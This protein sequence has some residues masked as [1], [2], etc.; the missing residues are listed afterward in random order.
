[1]R[2]QGGDPTPTA[3]EP[4]SAAALPARGPLGLG[5]RAGF[6]GVQFCATVTLAHLVSPAEFGRAAMAG[7]IGNF[8][9]V[10]ADLG[11]A[12]A[13]VQRPELAD[14][15]LDAAFGVSLAAAAALLVVL[16]A[17]A[18][19]LESVFAGAGVAPL[20]RLQGV[21]GACWIAGAVPRA[22]LARGL[23]TALLLRQ[24]LLA[25]VL[26]TAAGIAGALAGLGAAAVVLMTAVSCA[27][28]TV[29]AYRAARVR[30]RLRGLAAASP[31]LAVGLPLAALNVVA[32]WARSVDSLLIGR[33][34]GPVELGLYNRAY[35][36]MLLPLAQAGTLAASLLLPA[37]ARLQHDREAAR[38]TYLRAQGA[39]A[40]V[41]MPLLAV[42]WSA[43]DDL[44]AVLFGRA[45][46][47][48]GE[49]LRVLLLAGLLQVTTVLV[50]AACG[51][52]GQ[53]RAL[54]RQGL[55]NGPLTM[56]AVFWGA[57]YGTA[58]AVAW[59]YVGATLVTSGPVVRLAG[60]TLGFRVRDVLR[61]VAPASGCA[62]VAAAAVL[63]L[64]RLLTAWPA[65]PRLLVLLAAGALTYVALARAARIPGAEWL[66]VPGRS[67]PALASG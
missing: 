58:A 61:V 34:A 19:V 17:G 4:A 6:L 22:L 1:M 7:V 64:G 10:V 49:L 62:L 33:W 30:P 59:A 25:A 48:A 21:A 50:S 42:A 67:R 28:A 47:D 66:S 15:E 43:A 51:S 60:R 36:L 54:L 44:V 26:A 52:H 12:T 37:L 23:R 18:P 38:T 27:A 56:A 2:A 35:G 9:L 46:R 24:E 31:L 57:T 39:L 16:L 45:W 29:L 41:V 65:P 53:T 55:V 5:W 20:L 40:L 13:L 3:G 14:D 63:G 8:A 11:L 32:Y